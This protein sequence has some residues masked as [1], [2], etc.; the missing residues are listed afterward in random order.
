MRESSCRSKSF[1]QSNWHWQARKKANLFYMS[2]ASGNNEKHFFLHSYSPSDMFNT[3]KYFRSPLSLSL[4]LN[5]RSKMAHIVNLKPISY[6][7]RNLKKKNK[8]FLV[9]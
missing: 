7:M 4:T 5:L 2:C 6:L 1:E 8:V 9:T 3:Q